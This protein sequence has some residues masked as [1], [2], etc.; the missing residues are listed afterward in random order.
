MVYPNALA[1]TKICVGL[2]SYIINE[3]WTPAINTTYLYYYL[4][5]GDRAPR[6]FTLSL[7]PFPPS[8]FPA[9]IFVRNVI[10][11]RTVQQYLYMGSKP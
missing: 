11:L 7:A 8:T 9:G 6:V 10:S 1:M 5:R 4:L 3:C 2:D